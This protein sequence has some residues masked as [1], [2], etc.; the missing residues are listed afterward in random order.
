NFL[1]TSIESWKSLEELTPSK[2]PNW[3]VHKLSEAPRQKGKCRCGPLY[4]HFAGNAKT[5]GPCLP[6]HLVGFPQ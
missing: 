1:T 6:R 5:L 3:G 2:R 4:L